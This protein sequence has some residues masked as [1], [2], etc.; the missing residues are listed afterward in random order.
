MTNVI[1]SMQVDSRDDSH[2]VV[3]HLLGES[4]DVLDDNGSRQ[5]IENA[6]LEFGTVLQEERAAAAVRGVTAGQFTENG[7]F[8]GQCR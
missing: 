2:V 5:L 6:P 3:S 8:L 4:L 7:T 1:E